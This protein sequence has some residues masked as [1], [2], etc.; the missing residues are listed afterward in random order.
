MRE[1]L[2]A[3]GPKGLPG[4]RGCR[5]LPRVAGQQK[6]PRSQLAATRSLT[7]PLGVEDAP[8]C[9]ARLLVLFRCLGDQSTLAERFQRP[10]LRSCDRWP[11]GSPEAG[12]AKA[13]PERPEQVLATAGPELPSRVPV[14]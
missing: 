3:V 2:P 11:R 6:L 1:L 12:L 4:P 5:S 14:P 13:I 7:L 8:A 9:L 10:S